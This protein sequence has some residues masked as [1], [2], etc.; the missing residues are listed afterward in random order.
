MKRIIA[1]LA[2]L[3]SLAVNAQPL[4]LAVAANAQFVIKELQADFKKRT[5]IETE[6]IIGSSGK[7]AA[8]IKNGAPYDF[9]LSAD[10][11]FPAQLYKEGFGAT[12]PKEYAQ[13]SLIVCSASAADLKNWRGLLLQTSTNKIALA[14]PDLAPYGKAARQALQQYGIWEKI[15]TRLV[16]GESIAQVNTYIT[17]GVVPLGFTTESLIHEYASKGKLHWARVEAKAYDPIRQGMLVLKHAQKERYRQALKFYNYLLS[18]PAQK[19]LLHY[20]YR[21]PS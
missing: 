16:Y 19:L 15:K 9:F 1:F 7:F 5:G 14:N 13:G 3:V 11:D 2:L 20:G 21:L 12:S 17:T 18:A 8:Q 6:A 10:M 4:R